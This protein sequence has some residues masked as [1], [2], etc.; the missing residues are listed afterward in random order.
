MR[1]HMKTK[2]CV[3][4]MVLV[5][6][7][8]TVRSFKCIFAHASY[9]VAFRI[10]AIV[11][12]IGIKETFLKGSKVMWFLKYSTL[13][14]LVYWAVCILRHQIRRRPLRLYFLSLNL[15]WIWESHQPSI[16]ARMEMT[17]AWAL[18]FC[19]VRLHYHQGLIR[20]GGHQAPFL[21]SVQ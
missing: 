10:F 12:K 7:P 9:H 18:P 3:V 11:Y 16:R 6:H 21:Q 4:L 19:I 20:A 5:W 17:G 2:N 13:I 1:N 8:N 14:L 15:H